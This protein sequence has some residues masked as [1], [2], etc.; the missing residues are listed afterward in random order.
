MRYA[1]RARISLDRH[2]AYVVAP[3][4]SVP[5][6]KSTLLGAS[7][8]SRPA[9]GRRT[10]LEAPISS[11]SIHGARC[12]DGSPLSGRDARLRRLRW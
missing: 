8:K 4:S 10:L 6:D 11:S 5:P 9:G 3:T 7:E 1:E 2:A 12:A